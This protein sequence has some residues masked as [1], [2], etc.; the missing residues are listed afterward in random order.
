MCG[1]AQTGAVRDEFLR[2][3]QIPGQGVD[4]IALHVDFG[5]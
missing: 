3:D 4:Q 2:A 5:R 1:I